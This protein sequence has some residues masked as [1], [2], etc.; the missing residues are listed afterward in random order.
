MNGSEFPAR[1][2]VFLNPAMIH[3]TADELGQLRTVLRD[4]STDKLRFGPV[5]SFWMVRSKDSPL[6]SNSP[7][8]WGPTEWPMAPCP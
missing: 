5:N 8:R 4:Q 7:V 2:V 6:G 3:R 1:L